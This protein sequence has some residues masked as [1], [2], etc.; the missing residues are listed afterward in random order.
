MCD[1]LKEVKAICCKSD[2]VV[3]VIGVFN[4]VCAMDDAFKGLKEIGDAFSETDKETDESAFVSKGI[5]GE[6]TTIGFTF[7]EVETTGEKTDE[8]LGID[9]RTIGGGFSKI[10]ETGGETDKA[11]LDAVGTM[12]VECSGTGT[13]EITDI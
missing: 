7:N 13:G 2:E 12:C 9:P 3:I 4:E 11:G 1:R 10:I 5:I 6:L 8:V